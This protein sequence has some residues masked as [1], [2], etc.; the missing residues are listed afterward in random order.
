MNKNYSNFAYKHLGLL[1]ASKPDHPLS[2]FV[3]LAQYCHQNPITTIKISISTNLRNF[4]EEKGV[5]AYN[6]RSGMEIQK[7]RQYVQ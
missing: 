2:D 1:D 6:A 5:D 7:K 3:I 4:L